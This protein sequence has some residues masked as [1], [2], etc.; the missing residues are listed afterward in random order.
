MLNVS[1]NPR[2]RLLPEREDNELPVQEREGDFK[3]ICIG[4][5][6]VHDS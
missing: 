5:D 4:S 1:H 3:W 2:S 6:A